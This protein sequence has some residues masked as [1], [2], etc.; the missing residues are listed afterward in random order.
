MYQQPPSHQPLYTQEDVQRQ[1][2][3]EHLNLLSTFYY[4]MAGLSALS[5]FAGLFYAIM[6]ASIGKMPVQ[7]GRPGEDFPGMFFAF[8]GVIIMISAA[9]G[10]WLNIATASALKKR[11]GQ[12][13]IQVSAALHCIS[14][15]LG[16]ILGVFTFIVLNRPSIKA[17]FDGYNYHPK[18]DPNLYR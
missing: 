12:V 18:E 6:G 17:L 13:L 4:I 8:F 5:I 2:D 15:P 7:P 11:T 14:F 3:N 16:T 10:T 1:Q 9:L